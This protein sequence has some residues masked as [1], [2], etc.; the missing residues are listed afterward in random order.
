MDNSPGLW[1]FILANMGTIIAGGL[2]TILSFLAYRRH[3]DQPSYRFATLGFGLIVVGS[4]SDGA[5]LFG[6]SVDYRLGVTELLV[7]SAVEEALIAVG[8]GCLFYAITQHKVDESSAEEATS[9][10][11]DEEISWRDT[12]WNDD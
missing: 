5:Y 4:I 10:A 6:W 11:L 1:A 2:L 12:Q 7:L 3:S 8:L 9:R